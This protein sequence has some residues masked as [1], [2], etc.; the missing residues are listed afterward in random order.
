MHFLRGMIVCATGKLAKEL[1]VALG[2]VT[3][4]LYLRTT[5][6]LA[7]EQEI[8]EQLQTHAPS[9]VFLDVSDPD[10]ALQVAGMIHAQARNAQI[11]GVG[12]ES[13]RDALFTVVRGGMRDLIS[14]PFDRKEIQTALERVLKVVRDN[15]SAGR[16]EQQ[17]IS[18]LPA[19]PGSGASTVALQTAFTISR[20]GNSG[21]ALLDLDFDC[22]VVD[23]M[24]KLPFGLGLTDIIEYGPHLDDSVW[25]RIVTKFGDLD[26]LRSGQTPVGRRITATQARHML[27][28]SRRKYQVVCADLPGSFDELSLSV[29]AQS[30]QIMLVC[31][32]DLSN[33][34]MARK[35]L[36]TLTEL[37]LRDKVRLVLNRHSQK[38]L[39]RK[40]GVQDVLGMGVSLTLPNEY[41]MLQQALTNGRPVDLATPFGRCFTEVANSILGIR[42]DAV[43]ELEATGLWATIR[44][45]LFP[46][47]KQVSAPR[48]ALPAPAQVETVLADDDTHALVPTFKS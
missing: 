30:T 10:D 19:K 25:G 22:G 32:P 11:I 7:R 26:V 14:F 18:F 33:L 41:G 20:F 16:P 2:E 39:L 44:S 4:S 24:L 15:P 23:F 34:H 36:E 31:T 29:L 42:E 1:E 9:V 12:W 35:R 40:D 28:F 43:E 45:I 3:S 8:E 5:L 38:A 13:S 48:L 46:A 27:D 21:T 47:R 37:G 6:G 17:L